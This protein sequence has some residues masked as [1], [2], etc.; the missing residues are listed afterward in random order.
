MLG[1]PRHGNDPGTHIHARPRDAV[2]YRVI[3][4][5]FP[6][7]GDAGAVAEKNQVDQSALSDSGDILEQA[8]VGVMATDTP[9]QLTPGRFNL[10]PRHIDCQ[11]HLCLHG[12]DS[13][14]IGPKRAGCMDT[15]LNGYSI[16]D[17]EFKCRRT[18]RVKLTNAGSSVVA[19]VRGRGKSTTISPAI[20]PGRGD[21]TSSDPRE[22]LL[23]KCC[24]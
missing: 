22:T 13:I 17:A 16:A 2:A 20:R 15:L 21:M 5:A 8:D 23:P 19:T 6:R 1:N 24:E 3:D 14:R 11:M 12:V 9:P 10:R 18:S 7:V 4:R